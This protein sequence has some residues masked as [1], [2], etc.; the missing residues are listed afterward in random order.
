MS[1]CHACQKANKGTYE[2]RRIFA[3]LAYSQT[4]LKIHYNGFCQH[5]YRL[6]K[7]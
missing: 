2:V 1:E 3:T 4:E 5:S 6:L 7:F